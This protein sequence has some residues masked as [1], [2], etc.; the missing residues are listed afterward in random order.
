MAVP[1][2]I[3]AST[4]G[5]K[6]VKRPI[7]TYSVPVPGSV[8][9]GSIA[10]P[11]PASI[12]GSVPVPGSVATVSRTAST[13]KGM[14]DTAAAAPTLVQPT[15]PS[16]TSPLPASST[17]LHSSSD[18]AV[19]ETNAVRADKMIEDNDVLETVSTLPASGNVLGNVP[20]NVLQTGEIQDITVPVS[21]SG[22]QATPLTSSLPD[23]C[24]SS[25]TSSSVSSTSSS[26]P[27]SYPST[28][29]S[30]STSTQ[31]S[32][33]PPPTVNPQSVAVSL[34]IADSAR[35]VLYQQATEGRARTLTSTVMD[36]IGPS[37]PPVSPVG[38]LS[39]PT[40]PF[41]PSSS[42]EFE[43][44]NSDSNSNIYSMN[45]RNKN[46]KNIERKKINESDSKLDGGKAFI[47][48]Y[49]P[50]T[51]GGTARRAWQVPV[52][53]EGQSTSSL[54]SAASPSPRLSPT[55]SQLSN[56]RLQPRPYSSFP[57][58]PP[59][60]SSSSLISS[61]S[62]KAGT[63]I[64][65]SI[66]QPSSVMSAYPEQLQEAELVRRTYGLGLGISTD[67]ENIDVDVNKDGNS[68]NT[69]LSEEEEREMKRRKKEAEAKARSEW[70]GSVMTR[71]K[72]AEIRARKQEKV[73]NIRSPAKTFSK[74]KNSP[75]PF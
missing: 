71:A 59:P 37:G 73:S 39:S 4:W 58:H 17:V 21:T 57:P 9:T 20:E 34:G 30:S 45:S 15:L 64:S 55:L 29:S 35:K 25:S 47:D 69:D 51:V 66:S 46:M 52:S 54:L 60:P 68:F 56:K 14:E 12:T 67:G 74:E 3:E 42:K 11:T 40:Q 41:T 48:G 28:S 36:I 5:Q 63:S 44:T 49:S 13:D 32:I 38:P 70:V 10:I 22:T 24:T 33:S 2:A 65:V 72:N 53:R 6:S 75:W 8:P 31:S 43:T 7:T 18:A 16:S 27:P 62:L 26:L 19:V 1:Q 50:A 23:T 61:Q